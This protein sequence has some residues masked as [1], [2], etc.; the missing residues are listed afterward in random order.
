[1]SNPVP[2][3][4][5]AELES[6]FSMRSQASTASVDARWAIAKVSSAIGWMWSR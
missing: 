2:A 1:L 4:T 6:D 5:P 3:V